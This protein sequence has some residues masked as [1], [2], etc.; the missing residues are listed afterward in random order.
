M[1]GGVLEG[2]PWGGECIVKRRFS[3]RHP[4][5]KSRGDL[6]LKQRLV[7]RSSVSPTIAAFLTLKQKLF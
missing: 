7:E 5:R 1:E 4:N 2:K 6:G 3:H